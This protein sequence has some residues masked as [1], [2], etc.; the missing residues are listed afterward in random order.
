MAADASGTAAK[1]DAFLLLRIRR[2][3]ICANVETVAVASEEK[4]CAVPN[5]VR[6]SKRG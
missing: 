1:I 4:K 6:S 3:I 5:R 2:K